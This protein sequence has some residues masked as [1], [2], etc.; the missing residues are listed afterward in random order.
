M[1]CIRVQGLLI[2]FFC[3]LIKWIKY[4]KFTGRSSKE[5][6]LYVF[7]PV[8][9]FTFHHFCCFSAGNS[10]LLRRKVCCSGNLESEAGTNGASHWVA[11]I[12]ALTW[13]TQ[14]AFGGQKHLGSPL[15]NSHY[16][17]MDLSPT[18]HAIKKAIRLCLTQ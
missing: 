17:V 2:P 5:A 13:D 3:L 10:C 12:N 14:R 7:P 15:G 4:A 8:F 6:I 16:T 18:S 1:A 11:F 9:Q